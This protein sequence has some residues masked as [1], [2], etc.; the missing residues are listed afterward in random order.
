MPQV[1]RTGITTPL[2]ALVLV[3]AGL[4]MGRGEESPPE[5]RASDEA[6]VRAEAAGSAEAERELERRNEKLEAPAFAGRKG[7]DRRV[8]AIERLQDNS[9]D[10]QFKKTPFDR[11]IDR[12]P[13]RE[14]PLDVLQ[15]V[16]TERSRMLEKRAERERF[17]RMSEREQARWLAPQ[18]SNKL[19]ARVDREDFFGMSVR[20]RAAAVK[21]FYRDAEKLFRKRGIRDFVLVVTPYTKTTERL[22]AFAIGRDGSVSLTPLGATGRAGS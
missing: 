10:K 21:A 5:K 12:L 14:P 19:Y 9:F 15:W 3:S 6:L 17:Y 22:P 20:E 11:G 1:P 8:A 16:T 2:V 18:R 13:L 7:A 4:V